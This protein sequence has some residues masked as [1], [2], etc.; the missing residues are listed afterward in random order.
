MLIFPPWDANIFI[1]FLKGASLLAWSRQVAGRVA[2]QALEG[3]ALFRI[4]QDNTI[5]IPGNCA[6]RTGPSTIDVFAVSAPMDKEE[7]LQLVPF[8]LILAE[9]RYG[10]IGA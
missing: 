3:L 1:R 7:P 6:L 4:D 10:E 9:L 5:S 8:R 2:N